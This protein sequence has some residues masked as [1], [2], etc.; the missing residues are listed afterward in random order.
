MKNKCIHGFTII[1]MAIV[2]LIVGLLLGGG[3]SVLG[4]QM[5]MQRVKGTE[6]LP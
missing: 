1:E 5:E 3:L 6:R 2:L 4:V